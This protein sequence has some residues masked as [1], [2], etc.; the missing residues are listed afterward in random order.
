MYL[1]YTKVLT[2]IGLLFVAIIA[3]IMPAYITLSILVLSASF[4]GLYYVLQ[5]YDIDYKYWFSFIG[6]L[7]ALIL[8]VS[9]FVIIFTAVV[10]L[11]AR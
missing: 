9:G 5:N 4:I 2:S 3:S 11:I 7:L 10:N 6:Q 8:I 1:N